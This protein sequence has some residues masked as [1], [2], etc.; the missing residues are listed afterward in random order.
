MRGN[1]DL[2][3][4][5]EQTRYMRSEREKFGDQTWNDWDQVRITAFY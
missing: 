3:F 1:G 5:L 2:P 4:V